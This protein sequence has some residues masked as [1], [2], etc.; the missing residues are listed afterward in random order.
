MVSKYNIS[1]KEVRLKIISCLDY[2]GA[3]GLQS[4]VNKFI[5]DNEIKSI[6]YSHNLSISVSDSD[7][8]A[9][10]RS[11]ERYVAFIEYYVKKERKK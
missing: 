11:K 1:N 2:S 6:K 7:Y 3:Y 8:G 9:I 10:E 5:K 4:E